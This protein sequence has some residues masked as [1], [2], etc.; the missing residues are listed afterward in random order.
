MLKPAAGCYSPGIKKNLRDK[1]LGGAVGMPGLAC[2]SPYKPHRMAQEI[3]LRAD[4]GIG[5]W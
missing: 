4:Q 1:Y 3:H 5:S 2:C